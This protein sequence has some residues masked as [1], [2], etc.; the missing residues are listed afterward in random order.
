VV[1][2][3]GEA[4][5]ADA[6]WLSGADL[7]VA[8]DGGARWLAAM[9]VR[10]DVVVGDLDSLDSGEQERL[11]AAGTRI[12]RH[13]VAKDASDTELAVEAAV[14]AGADE[15]VILG[16]LGGSRLDHELANLVLLADDRWDAALDLRIVR[17]GTLVRALRGGRRLAIEAPTGSVVT[18][19]PMAGDAEGVRTGGLR[20]PLE[21]ER[22]AFGRSRGLSNE[23]VED[24]AWV[25][26]E[27]GVMLVI[28]TTPGGGDT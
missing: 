17:G 9:R 21:G 22:L 8:A 2:A 5:P 11:A 25:S 14:S 20:Y 1:V 23:A 6:R 15:V 13:P 26:L 4:D 16:A 28:E 24:E 3:D 27:D 7:V 18:L 19:L 12:D 10:P